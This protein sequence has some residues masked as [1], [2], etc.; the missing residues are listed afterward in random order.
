VRRLPV[1]ALLI[2][3]AGCAGSAPPPIPLNPV[4][5]LS[6][7]DVYVAD[8]L[9][10]DRGGLA[11]VATVRKR[12][13]D[14]GPVVFV[15]AGDLL[16]PSLASKYFRGRQMIEA[17]NSAKLDYATFGNHEFDIEPDTLLARIAESRFKWISSNCTR[18]DGTP[19]PKVL[20]WDTLRVSGHK[21]GLFGLTLQGTYPRYVQC[22]NP[23][24]AAH[25]VIETLSSEGADLIVGL[26]HQTMEADRNLLGRE[27]KLDLILGGHEHEAQDSVVSG[28]H[29]V[30][31]DADAKT[32]QFVTLWGGKGNWRQAVGQVVI[33][34]SLPGDTAVTKV[35]TRW[36]DSLQRKL[37]PA[38]PVGSTTVWIG[39]SNGVSRRKESV[40]GDLVTDAMRAGTGADV[41]LLNSGTLR[42]D[43]PIQPGPIT[44]HELEAIFPF[45]DQTRVVTF[46][47]TGARLRRLLEHAVS[48]RVLGTGGFLQ[49]SGVAFAYD[50]R[51]PS[52]TRVVG[53]LRRVDGKVVAPGDTITAAFNVY[54]ACEGGDG[55]SV[56]EAVPACGRRLS[57]PRAV[58]LLTQY[59]TDSL[60][61]R[62][63]APKAERVVEAGTTNP[64]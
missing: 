21:V 28:R 43:H 57:A 8:T 38:H 7:N 29:A 56:P 41:A 17:L 64:G 46:P 59:I 48:E 49:V 6:I 10:D 50:P 45:P 3:V 47:V 18:P 62:I 36:S 24:T 15:L 63:Q 11:R 20:P 60:G 33:N 42:L 54:T 52:G 31:A 27:P 9:A 4:R 26:T 40:L 39:P 53:D 30:K 16:S 61:G 37:G 34:G 22:S 58:D 1:L 13:A 44:N 2:G 5:F 51:R 25:R 35:V 19:F 32:A 14:Q 55:Y 12:L 23:D